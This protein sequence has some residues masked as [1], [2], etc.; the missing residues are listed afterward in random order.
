MRLWLRSPPVHCRHFL[1][2]FSMSAP[3]AS[4]SVLSGQPENDIASLAPAELAQKPQPE[5]PSVTSVLPPESVTSEK[6][7]NGIHRDIPL[8][9]VAEA[10]GAVVHGAL[11]SADEKNCKSQI[12]LL[13]YLRI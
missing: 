9:V 5:T 6:T 3:D 12:C 7:E 11:D 10:E 8:M 4:S 2:L 1:P 13:R